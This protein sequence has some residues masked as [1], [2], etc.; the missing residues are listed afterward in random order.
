MSKHPLQENLYTYDFELFLLG[1]PQIFQRGK[2]LTSHLSRR[3]QALLFFLVI[4]NKTYSRTYLA[5][6]FW[7]NSPDVQAKKNLRNILPEL[8]KVFGNYLRIDATSVSFQ[9]QDTVWCDLFSLQKLL[10]EVESDAALS[11]IEALLTLYR[12]ELLTGFFVSSA[13][14]FEE[15]ITIERQR[16]SPADALFG[17]VWAK[18]C[19]T[20][21]F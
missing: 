7:P 21:P 16:T 3:A 2:S 1:A 8:R 17:A 18:E 19:S 5:S 13:P 14:F 15:W 11:Q 4:E 6:L 20:A 9:L 10:N 12:G